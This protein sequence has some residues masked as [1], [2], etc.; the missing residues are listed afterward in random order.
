MDPSPRS[1]SFH[2]IHHLRKEV[3]RLVEIGYSVPFVAITESWLKDHI[4][5]AQINIDNFNTFR[6]DRKISGHGGTVL[7][8]NKKIII[9]E[10]SYFDDNFCSGIIC[11]SRP[12]KTIFSC[13]YRPPNSGRDSFS[14][15]LA[16]LAKFIITHNSSDKL[17]ILLFGDFNLPQV[18]WD[19][20]TVTSSNSEN[21]C[22]D[23]NEFM[24]SLLLSQYVHE[25]TRLNNIL[26]LFITIRV[27]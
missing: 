12:T 23:L 21:M 13:I 26:D 3:D 7:F 9:N 15:L 6:S 22:T 14:K 11:L 18:V 4:T 5:D 25:N 2:K 8:V 24:D 17:K 20:L 16:F 27:S 19:D 1:K 10:I